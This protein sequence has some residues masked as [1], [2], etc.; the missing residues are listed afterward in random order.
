MYMRAS[1]EVP[2]NSVALCHC[3]TIA[4]VGIL[5][6]DHYLEIVSCKLLCDPTTYRYYLHVSELA[7]NKLSLSIIIYGV[8]PGSI[9]LVKHTVYDSV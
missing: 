3:H 1:R 5:G 2:N 9:C 7:T 6:P 8:H 4:V